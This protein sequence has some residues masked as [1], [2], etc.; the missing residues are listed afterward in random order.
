MAKFDN[1]VIGFF[2]LLALVG[3]LSRYTQEPSDRFFPNVASIYSSSEKA[4]P[5]ALL[6]APRAVPEL[7]AVNGNGSTVTL[8]DF[9]GKVVLLNIWA[10]WCIPCNAD[11]R[12]LARLQAKLGGD[13]FEV[14]ALSVDQG[15]PARVQSFY[16]QVGISQLGLYVDRAGYIVRDLNIVGI[17]TALLIG[18]DGRE[19]ARAVGPIDWDS[20]E[21]ISTIERALYPA[22]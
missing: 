5:L 2:F 16:E 19:L 8:S 22:P 4:S 1:N 15:G 14:V 20:E 3:G 9:H 21:A 6:P 10:T 12:H 13:S 18:K 17:P 7:H 11:I